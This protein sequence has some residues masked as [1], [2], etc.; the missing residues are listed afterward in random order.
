MLHPPLPPRTQ[1]PVQSK[2][3]TTI[4]TPKGSHI[5]AA[6]PPNFKINHCNRRRLPSLSA[7]ALHPYQQLKLAA[8][9]SNAFGP[10]VG[11]VLFNHSF[12]KRLLQRSSSRQQN[13]VPCMQGVISDIFYYYNLVFL[14]LFFFVTLSGLFLNWRF[15]AMISK[16]DLSSHRHL[17]QQSPPDTLAWPCSCFSHSCEQMGV[18]AVDAFAFMIVSLSVRVV[19]FLPI[20]SLLKP[21]VLSLCLMNSWFPLQ[22]RVIFG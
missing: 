22:H 2:H 14:S 21:L 18:V 9:W 11:R 19:V 3:L 17:T 16:P 15:P 4:T 10:F 1:V 8:Q 7:R 13:H 20:N 5:A 6:S 12:I